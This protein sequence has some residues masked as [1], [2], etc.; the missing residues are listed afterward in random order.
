MGVSQIAYLVFLL[1]VAGLDQVLNTLIAV[2]SPGRTNRGG[3]S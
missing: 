2:D 1:A 3:G